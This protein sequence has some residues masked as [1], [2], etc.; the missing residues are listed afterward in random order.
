MNSNFG[1]AGTIG[2]VA[3]AAAIA[4]AAMLISQDRGPGAT[5]TIATGKPGS[6]YH[7]LALDYQKHLMPYGINLKFED[8]Q[9]GFAALRALVDQNSGVQAAFV[10][11]GMVGSLQGRL[12]RGKGKEWREAELDNLRSVGRLFYEPIWVYTRGDLPI[13]SLRDLKDRKILVGTRESGSRRIASQLLRANGI[14]SRQNPLMINEDL[15]NDARQIVTGQAD[16]AIVI[17]AADSEKA[18]ALL[19]VPNIRLMNFAPEADAYTE[20]FPA[21]SRVV[22][23]RGSVEFQPVIP[24]ADI[25]LLSTAAVLVVRKDLHPALVSLL[26]HAVYSKP[27][28]GFDSAGDPVLFYRAGQFPNGNDSE[29]TVAEDA[30]QIYKSGELPLMLRVLAPLNEKIGIPFP[31]AAFANAH[32]AQ[33]ILLLIPALT[34]L[35][36]LIRVLPMLY[37]WSVRRRL[38]Y[39]YQQLKQLETKL[40]TGWPRSDWASLL[41]EI[42]RI[43]AGVRR[44]KMPLNFSDQFYDLRGHIDLVRQRINVKPAALRMAAE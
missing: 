10:K 38:L 23:R 15:D 6:D 18:Q 1:G 35:I 24:S 33:V 36:P 21:Y 31:V 26:T 25:T 29:F 5:I 44:I 3:V 22:L 28:S 37:S 13:E 20:R 4:G 14:E 2:A 32:G 34:I 42:D 43:E 17:A 7:R 40:D 11:G 27:R 16:A 39:W 8:T 9:E 19:R 30:R 41:A 12:A